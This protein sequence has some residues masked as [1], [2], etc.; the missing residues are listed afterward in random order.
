MLSADL[1][2]CQSEME[3]IFSLRTAPFSV[4]SGVTISFLTSHHDTQEM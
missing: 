1:D 4:A 2:L 3:D